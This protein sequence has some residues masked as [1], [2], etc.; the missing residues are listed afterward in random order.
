ME[1]GCV[2]VFRCGVGL[3]GGACVRVEYSFM[4][5]GVYVRYMAAGVLVWVGV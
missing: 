5:T 2:E 3:C 1:S 4:D